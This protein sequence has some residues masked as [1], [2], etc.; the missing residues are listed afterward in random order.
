MNSDDVIKATSTAMERL[1]LP[2]PARPRVEGAEYTFPEDPEELSVT[3]LGQKMLHFS[4]LHGHAQWRLGQLES[5]LIAISAEYRIRI[6]QHG[7]EWKEKAEVKR[8][9]ADVLEAAVLLEHPELMPLFQKKTELEAIEAQLESHVKI[10]ERA[11]AALSRELARREME[12]RA[13]G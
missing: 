13:G 1:R 11:W 10:Y 5:K 3:E 4:G 2:A 6:Q 12:V 8:P 9:S 7:L